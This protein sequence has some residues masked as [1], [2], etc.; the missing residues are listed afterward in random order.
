MAAPKEEKGGD[1]AEGKA[2]RKAKAKAAAATIRVK[3]KGSAAVKAKAKA[4]GEAKAKAAGKAKA[5]AAGEAKAKAAGKAKAK[6]AGK[7]KGKVEAKAAEGSQEPSLDADEEDVDEERLDNKPVMRRPAAATI[8]LRGKRP[9]RGE[10]AESEQDTA[11][12]EEGKLE[13][14]GDSGSLST[15]RDRVKARKFGEIFESVPEAIRIQYAEASARRLCTD[16][17]A[18]IS[19]RQTHC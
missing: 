15:L 10:E 4:A 18:N 14:H 19:N 13:E 1:K 7:A 6:A 16:W 3:S 2:K 12:Q 17:I 8:A 9:K 5:K 11:T